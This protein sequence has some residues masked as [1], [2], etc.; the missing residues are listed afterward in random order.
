M[1][2][3]DISIPISIALIASCLVIAGPFA[4]LDVLFLI[5]QSITPS[6]GSSQLIPTS[7]NWTS[8]PTNLEI[9]PTPLIFFG[10]F[11]DCK[12]VIFWLFGA[13]PSSY[14]PWSHAKD[15]TIFFVVSKYLLPYIPA[16]CI[17]I[18]S[19]FPKLPCGFINLSCL[20]CACS[21]KR[22]SNG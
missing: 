15:K 5:L 12:S 2:F 19:N 14:T 9:V 4:I 22:V 8:E 21:I 11:I 18:S 7:T 10:K 3:S 1:Y 13:T 17:L 6:I 16:N 20:A